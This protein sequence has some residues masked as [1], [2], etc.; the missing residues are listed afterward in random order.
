MGKAGQARQVFRS[1]GKNSKV[2]KVTGTE[3]S[4]PKTCK[5]KKG[6]VPGSVLILLAGR[7][8]GRRAVFLKQLESG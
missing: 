7:F 6:L 2:K 5:L 8:R 4:V 3:K 1:Y